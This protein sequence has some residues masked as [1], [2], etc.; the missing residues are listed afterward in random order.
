MIVNGIVAERTI[1]R[2][3]VSISVREDGGECDHQGRPLPRLI[4]S[5]PDWVQVASLVNESVD[6][7]SSAVRIDPNA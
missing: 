2:I 5:R 7:L 6:A 3:T 4:S 1:G